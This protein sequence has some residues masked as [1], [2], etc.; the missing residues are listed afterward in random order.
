MAP[1]R[2]PGLT[3]K[4]FTLYVDD[5]RYSVPTLFTVDVHDDAGAM[6]FAT[7]L[8]NSSPHYLAVEVWDD[9]RRVG[10]V[11]DLEDQEDS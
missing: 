11:R 7:E 6:A 10:K 4:I 2:W 5:D 3:V 1:H 9:D 8:L